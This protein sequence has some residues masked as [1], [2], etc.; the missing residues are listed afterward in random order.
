MGTSQPEGTRLSR[1]LGLAEVTLSG[2]GIILGAGIYALI[3]TAAAGAGNA[4]WLS[5][6]ISAIVA[7]FTALSYAELSSLF[8]KAGAEYEYST[9]AVGEYVAFIIGWLIIF[10][11]I[12]GAATVALGFGGYFSGLF[13]TGQVLAAVALISVLT[14]ILIIGVKESAVVAGVFTLIE[15]AG[16]ILIIAAGLPR[17]G[18]VDYL[19]MPLGISGVFS[20]AALVFFAYQGFEEMVKFSEETR[21]PEKTVPKALM[22]ALVVCTAL[23]ILVCISAVSVVGWEGLAGSDTPFAEVAMVAW[24]PRGAGLLSVIALFATANTVLLMLLA[25]SRISYGMA[26][27]GSLPGLFSRVHLTRKTP[28]LAILAAASGAVLFLFAGDIGFI[29]NVTNFTI[30]VT[31]IIVNL[32]VIILRFRCPDE[33]RPF[34]VP[35]SIGRIPVLPLFGIATS[36][37]LLFQLTPEIVAIGVILVIIGGI[38]ALFSGRRKDQD[39]EGE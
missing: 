7:L 27:S 25:A 36:L 3:G 29:A 35:G 14:V 12:I 38:V 16:L 11:G 20:A 26:R 1:S 31:F 39:R 13:G 5:F 37:F 33:I 24:G 15:V 8:P 32:S 28:Y 19:E 10:S 30:F 23:Y 9:A 34:R 4:V 18:S 21:E 2:I 6:A 17:L 22:I